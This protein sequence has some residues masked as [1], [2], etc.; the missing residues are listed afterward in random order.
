MTVYAY[1]PGVSTY[2]A[3]VFDL[4]A[5]EAEAMRDTAFI[6]Y[7]SPL[8]DAKSFTVKLD[9]TPEEGNYRLTGLTRADDTISLGLAV[10]DGTELGVME[11]GGDAIL[12]NGLYYSLFKLDSTVYLHVSADT[13]PVLLGK[14]KLSKDGT[15]YA[16]DNSCKNLTVSAS[17]KCD[18]ALVEDGGQ[19]ETV[20]VGDGGSVDVYGVVYGATIENGG[21]LTFKEGSRAFSDIITVNAGGNVTIEGGK[22]DSNAKFH[23]AGGTLTVNGPMQ[24]WEDD[25]AYLNPI[26]H[27]FVY[28]LEQLDATPSGVMISDYTLLQ[29]NPE[30]TVN[31]SAD[32]KNVSYKLMGNA[33]GFS[34]YVSLKVEGHDS[35]EYLYLGEDCLIG[36]SYYSL[37]LVDDVL[38]LTVSD[39]RP[40]HAPDVWADVTEPTTGSVLVTA[41]FDE[42]AKTKE[43]SLDGVTWKTYSKAVRF[44]S[45]GIV[46]FR[47][48]NAEGNTSPVVSYE[49]TNI[50][51]AA[52]ESIE[53]PDDGANGWLFDKS[54]GLV[55]EEVAESYGITLD[56]EDPAIV[57][58][59]EG[60]IVHEES[61]VTY[62]NFVGQDDSADFSKLV[63]DSGARVKFDLKATDAAKFVIYRLDYSEKKETY[64]LKALQTTSL[65]K[66]KNA[67][68]A[69]ATTK[70]L[71]LESGEYF[72]SMQAASTKAGAA[73]YYNVE[74]DGDNK[75]F[76][77]ADDGW[78]NSAYEIDPDTGK[79]DKTE[80][81]WN[82]AD[83]PAVI[84]RGVTELVLDDNEIGKDG[85]SNWVGF[86][87]AADYTMVSLESDAFLSF[88][89]SA[90]D[91]AKFTIWAVSYSERSGKWTL[92]GKGSVSVKANETKSMTPKL[93][94][95]G[96]YFISI[97]SSNAK[98]GG[99][100]YYNLSV[101]EKTVFFDS[102][103]DGANNVLY[104]KK[105]KT[106]V[107]DSHFVSTELIS[108]SQNISLDTNAMGN[109]D[110]EN[111]VGYGDAVDFAKIVLT[112][113]GSLRFDLTATGDATFA[114]YRKGT[115][116][117]GKA[118]LETIQTTKLTLAKGKT[119]VAVPTATLTGIAI[120]L[121]QAKV[122]LIE[123][124]NK[125]CLFLNWVCLKLGLDNV[126]VLN[127]KAGQ[128]D[129][130]KIFDIT[131]ER[132]MGKIDDVLPL[133][134]KNL[135]SG[136]Y[137]LAYQGPESM[138]S[139]EVQHKAEVCLQLEKKYF[140][141]CDEKMRKIAVFRKI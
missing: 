4:G 64:S 65:K 78:N 74:L 33:S 72:V 11:L 22:V 30:F 57:L 48:K 75:F 20:T 15:A 111:F 134:T 121:D 115:D 89:L 3:F 50:E 80:L 59:G 133:C 79:E 114:I 63:L 68:S 97:A 90:T 51:K 21:Q 49:V 109:A 129:I 135:K 13:A 110:Y 55:N 141:P 82:I 67:S 14:V 37:A 41:D 9:D 23:L 1:H 46:Y 58:D 31:L 119:T 88:T 103:D 73:A 91:K 93:L 108:G 122:K 126:E 36:D 28:D 5:H 47:A 77:D 86:G 44:T 61:G 39:T 116:K 139:Q 107:D 6:D 54:T 99:D 42:T 45:N 53:G 95:S 60:V 69:S 66:A 35:Q 52:P 124:L 100:A 19:L 38:T 106:F 101:G 81:N 123:S 131:T 105:T 12:Y 127:I 7:I 85:W 43:Y 32:R 104:V 29:C 112:S 94:A 27:W 140:L 117:K 83:H 2:A 16:S 132:A 137:F 8:S 70:A 24:G 40:V 102:A 96:E 87:D 130:D 17:D 18:Y 62:S 125:R 34:R 10:N 76:D 84:E 118:T 92:T 113:A 25:S 128:K 71:L 136:G 138:A 56:P 120:M 26:R 98:T